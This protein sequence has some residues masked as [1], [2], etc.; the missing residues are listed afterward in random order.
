MQT[1]RQISLVLALGA[2]ISAAGALECDDGVPVTVSGTIDTINLSQTIQV[3]QIHMVLTDLGGSEVFAGTGGIMGQIRGIKPD[4]TVLLNHY[5]C[6]DSSD[7]LMTRKDRATLMPA[8]NPLCVDGSV[9]RFEVVEIVSRTKGKGFFKGIEAA[10]E[11]NG[12]VSYCPENNGN[13]FVLT[14][15]AC[16]ASLD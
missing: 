8:A 13:H 15:E 3:G 10:I 1:I 5:I 2:T 12:T 4:G 9:G 14:G 7:C 16:V 6:F 11:A